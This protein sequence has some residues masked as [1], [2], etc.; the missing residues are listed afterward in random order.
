MTL[1]NAFAGLATEPTQVDV[2]TALN[3]LALLL[4]QLV[5]KTGYSDPTTGGQRVTVANTPNIGTVT[6]VTTVT[7]IG[8][9]TNIA[10]IGGIAAIYDQYSNMAGMARMLR[11]GIVIT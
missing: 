3:E 7:T 8:S 11:Q 1:R 4:N 2:S 5:S 6:T 10:Q 9:V